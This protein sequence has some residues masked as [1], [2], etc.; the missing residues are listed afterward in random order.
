MSAG[1]VVLTVIDTAHGAP[2]ETITQRFVAPG[3]SVGRATTNSLVLPDPDRSVSRTHV[4]LQFRKAGPRV[5]CVGVNAVSIN[6]VEIEQGEEAACADGDRIRIGTFT[7][8]AS[9][10]GS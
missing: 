8:K 5:I 6:G 4:R 10:Q 3:G 9:V 7:L 1:A 2:A